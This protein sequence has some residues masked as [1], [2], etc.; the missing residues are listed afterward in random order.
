MFFRK[1]LKDA[2]KMMSSLRHSNY[3]V[4][5]RW[6]HC[7]HNLA[8]TVKLYW[9]WTTFNRQENPI[10]HKTNLIYAKYSH[11]QMSSKLFAH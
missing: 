1:S 3:S 9:N 8:E 10:A 4:Y 2:D 11:C 6:K 7:V 5:T